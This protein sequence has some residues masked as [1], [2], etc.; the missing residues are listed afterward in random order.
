[1]DKVEFNNSD[2]KIQVNIINDMMQK[3]GYSLRKSCES[4]GLNKSTIQSRFKKAGYSLSGN[5]YIK[6][7]ILDVVDKKVQLIGLDEN[8]KL[9]R[10]SIKSIAVHFIHIGKSLLRIKTNELYKERGF[11]NFFDYA[12]KTFNIRESTVY[13]LINISNSFGD[14][15]L[16]IKKEYENFSYTQL[17]EMLSLPKEVIKDIKSSDTVKQ[18]KD[19]KK[20]AK[21]KNDV[22]AV[23][24]DSDSDS[25]FEQTEIP[26]EKSPEDKI[27]LVLQ[28]RDI[29]ELMYL[30]N[31]NKSA[32][33]NSNKKLLLKVRSKLVDSIV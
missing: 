30:I 8:E 13:N 22:S 19:K 9:I 31:L 28:R 21:E 15:I 14:P 6:D 2:I 26:V 4:I 12:Y 29:E 24:I 7:W 5:Q 25:Y 10:D 20:K 16:G 11:D 3:L 23:A 1:M 32:L 27:N 18:I 17:T 33:N